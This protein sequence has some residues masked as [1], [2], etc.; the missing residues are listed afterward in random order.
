ME[1]Q[2]SATLLATRSNNDS[3][4]P[5]RASSHH[6][7]R[8][9]CTRTLILSQHLT[10]VDS[11]VFHAVLSNAICC[12]GMSGKPFVLQTQCTGVVPTPRRLPQHAAFKALPGWA[13]IP[14]QQGTTYSA[15]SGI[16]PAD[17][18]G[19]HLSGS[20][21]CQTGPAR[22]GTSRDQRVSTFFQDGGLRWA[23][24]DGV[25]D[26]PPRRPGRHGPPWQ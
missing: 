19:H 22:Q 9:T 6:R 18:L 1:I 21:G 3:R 5:W 8:G 11:C 20:L 16:S 25:A 2:P 12:Q 23:Q 26:W 13:R 15:A 10:R 7:P 17:G 24:A 14:P 4:G